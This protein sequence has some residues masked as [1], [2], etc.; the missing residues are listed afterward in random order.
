MLFHLS[1][2]WENQFPK[3]VIQEKASG[4]ML[5]PWW[6]TQNWFSIMTQLL[7]VYPIILPKKNAT[8]TLLLHENKPHPLYPKLQLQAIRLSGKQWEIKAFRRKLWTSFVSHGETQQ[9]LVMKG[10][11]DS[12]KTISAKGVSIPL[13]QM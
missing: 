1:V 8:L 5:I 9:H 4:V 3:S 6:V 11:S 2:Q 12:G 7:V 10:Y 13:L